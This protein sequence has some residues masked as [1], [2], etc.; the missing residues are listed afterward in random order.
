MNV[1]KIWIYRFLLYL[2]NKELIINWGLSIL[3]IPKLVEHFNYNTAAKYKFILYQPNC[4]VL[5]EILT[6]LN[7]QIENNDILVA[8]EIY[9]ISQEITLER[10]F[11]H[12]S[13][14]TN[15]TIELNKLLINIRQLNKYY[16][17]IVAASNNLDAMDYRVRTIKPIR[18]QM[19]MIYLKLLEY[20]YHE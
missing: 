8:K 11:I 18:D 16:N 6:K 13:K 19:N 1:I 2:N 12:Q 3:D 20:Y 17:E 15:I 14:Y 9:I 5:N 7:K 10:F 4:I